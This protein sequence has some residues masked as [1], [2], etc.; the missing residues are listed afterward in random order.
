MRQFSTWK[1]CLI[2]FILLQDV[3]GQDKI[4]P[5]WRHYYMGTQGLIFVVD[6][7]DRDRIDEARQELHRIINDREMREAIILVFANKQ[8]L[9]EGKLKLSWTTSSKV[10]CLSIFTHA[11]F[12]TLYHAWVLWEKAN[13]IRAR[14]CLYSE[15]A[16]LHNFAWIS[17]RMDQWKK[18]DKYCD[19][20]IQISK[21]TSNFLRMHLSNFVP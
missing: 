1:K 2:S 18:P 6:C 11:Y 7:A 15:N 5:L 3:G 14:F 16:F 19:Q 12:F 9:Q 10:C 20:T 13:V 17:L 4:R 8:D 21:V